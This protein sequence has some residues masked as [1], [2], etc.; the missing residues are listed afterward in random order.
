MQAMLPILWMLCGLPTFTYR[1]PDLMLVNPMCTFFA[2]PALAR[3]GRNMGIPHAP[4][5]AL[6][7]DPVHHNLHMALVT[8]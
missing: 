4:P 2:P 7:L 1:S 6:P 3:E 5:G 8:M